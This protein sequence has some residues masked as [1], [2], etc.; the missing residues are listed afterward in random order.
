MLASVPETQRRNDDDE[1]FCNADDWQ[2]RE[3]NALEGDEEHAKTAAAI[4]EP[5]K[6]KRKSKTT[7]MRGEN[8][9]YLSRSSALVL[10]YA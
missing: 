1:V 9:R 2:G 6:R 3:E 7:M 8:S 5:R 4:A 10:G